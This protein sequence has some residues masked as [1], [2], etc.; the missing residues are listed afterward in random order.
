MLHYLEQE[1]RN[2]KTNDFRA[3]IENVSRRGVLGG[4]LTTT[5]LVLAIDF[6]PAAAREVVKP[7][8]TGGDGMP[9]KTV[10]DPKV[11]IAIGK[12][13][14]VTIMSHRAEMGTG[15]A[16]S[17]PMVVADELEA[18]W[19]KVKIVATDGDE[20]KYGNQDTDGSRSM[21][22]FIQAMRQCGAAM[23]SMLEV[24]SGRQVGRRCCALQ[25]Q[26]PQGRSHRQGRQRT[27]QILHLRRTCRSGDGATCS[28]HRHP[29]PQVSRRIQLHGQ[30]RN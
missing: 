8:P 12:D 4:L 10:N 28:G 5:G 7:Y 1:L 25:R 21:R 19:S 11:F 6:S 17:L 22:H 20:P 27:G 24:G 13:D 18:D 16:T 26:E 9:N 30:G 15:V 3:S 23:R 14:M 2:R 29:S